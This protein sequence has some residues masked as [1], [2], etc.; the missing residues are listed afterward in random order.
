MCIEMSAPSYP[1]ARIVA[2]RLEERMAAN[3]T[4]FQTA[5]DT[6]RPDARIIEDLITTAFWASLQ[7]EEGR[8]PLISLA[9]MPPEQSERPVKF[10]SLLPLQPHVLAQLAPAVEQPGIH[11]GVWLYGAELCTWGFTRTVPT[12]C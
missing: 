2:T 11:I 8:A 7:R 1:A 9:F 3:P 6:P 4:A 10:E 5:A 12:W